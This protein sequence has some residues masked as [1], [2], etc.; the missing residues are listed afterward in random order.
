MKSCDMIL[1][2]TTDGRMVVCAV[3]IASVEGGNQYQVDGAV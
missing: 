2:Q 1:E 3:S